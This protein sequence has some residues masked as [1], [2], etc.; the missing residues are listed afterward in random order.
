MEIKQSKPALME[1]VRKIIDAIDY[2]E[3][4]QEE[5]VQEL[6][7]QLDQSITR[8]RDAK[9]ESLSKELDTQVKLI[10]KLKELGKVS[11]VS[12]EHHLTVLQ[13]DPCPLT[14]RDISNLFTLI[15]MVNPGV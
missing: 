5:S 14:L 8:L 13:C 3:L 7:S 4:E 11:S 2:F 12:L 10:G 15:L 6:L 9:N 1:R